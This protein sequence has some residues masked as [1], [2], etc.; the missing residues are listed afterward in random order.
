VENSCLSTD[1]RIILADLVN[2]T[3][4]PNNKIMDELGHSLGLNGNG[5]EN[6]KVINGREILDRLL[7]LLL[8]K[9]QITT[10]TKDS[11]TKF[12]SETNNIKHIN[13]IINILSK[14]NYFNDNTKITIDTLKDKIKL[15]DE[16][17]L[18]IENILNNRQWNRKIIHS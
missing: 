1:D 12:I 5:N 2:R 9:K 14:A 7:I 18:I 10:E 17:D 11:L 15:K 4:T 3:L 6:N 13:I 8:N 16:E